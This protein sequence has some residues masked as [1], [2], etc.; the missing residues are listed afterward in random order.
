MIPRICGG[1]SMI[2]GSM[3]LTLI[4]IPVCITICVVSLG[5]KFFNIGMNLI[6]KDF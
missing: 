3:L 6:A 4:F 1:L 5:V 2:C